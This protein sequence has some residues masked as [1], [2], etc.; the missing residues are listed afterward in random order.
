LFASSGVANIC[1]P[2]KDDVAV[3][4]PCGSKLPMGA[5]HEEQAMAKSALN[6]TAAIGIDT[7]PYVA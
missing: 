5:E 3:L 7:R 1:H 4:V 2:L 6:A